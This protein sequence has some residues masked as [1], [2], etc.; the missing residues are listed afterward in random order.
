MASINDL[1]K[2]KE[3]YI[4]YY[5][6]SPTNRMTE[7]IDKTKKDIDIIKR[8]VKESEKIIKSAVL[9]RD[10]DKSMRLIFCDSKDD[11]A[12][13]NMYWHGKYRTYPSAFISNDDTVFPEI[14]F[15]DDEPVEVEVIIRKKGEELKSS[16][17]GDK[18]S[19]SENKDGSFL[20]RFAD[21][22][23]DDDEYD[24]EEI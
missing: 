11:L 7:F 13:N 23:K 19:V 3:R 10:F 17:V 22:L 6:D 24:I 9:V 12:K 20:K 4:E 1:L 18:Q 21:F 2:A 5:K 16:G 14:T 15:N 8:W